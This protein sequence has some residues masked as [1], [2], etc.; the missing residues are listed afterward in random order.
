V[1]VNRRHV[2]AVYSEGRDRIRDRSSHHHWL[3][4]RGVTPWPADTRN[5]LVSCPRWHR[6]PAAERLAYDQNRFSREQITELPESLCK[7]SYLAD[8]TIDFLRRHRKDPFALYV[9]FFKPHSPISSPRNNQFNPAD[10]ALPAAHDCFPN[11][12]VPLDPL[13]VH[14]DQFAHGFDGS[15]VASADDQRRTIARYWG[16]C[17]LVDTHVGRILAA[18]DDLNLSEETLVVF[19][20]DHGEMMSAHGMWGKGVMYEPSVR[21]PM[22]IHLPGQKRSGQVT[23]PTSQI[24]MVPTLID[25]LGLDPNVPLPGRSWRDRIEQNAPPRNVIIEWNAVPGTDGESA[26]TLVTPDGWKLTLSTRGQHELR[27]LR[28]DP[29]ETTNLMNQSPAQARHL[30]DQIQAWQRETGDTCPVITGC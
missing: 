4:S 12:S 15:P 23:G 8:E 6:A 19:T 26:R 10:I 22:M 21:V 20:T 16:M 3:V 14:T 5:T 17:S 24:D 25:Y 1:A 28:D 18:L 29:L 9:N 11:A 30:T 7:P 13:R 27:N 2:L